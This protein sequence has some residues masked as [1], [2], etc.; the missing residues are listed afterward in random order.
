METL[1]YL[2]LPTFF[3]YCSDDERV[4]KGI[5]EDHKIRF[6]QPPALNDPLE[7]N[8]IIRFKDDADNYRSFELNGMLF[9]SE[10]LRLRAALIENKVNAFGILSLTK[11]PDS[12]DMWSRYATGH[13]GF[14]LEFKPDFNKCACM[15]STNGEEYP[16]REVTYVEEYALDIQELLDDQKWIA[17]QAVNDRMFFT[18]TSR[19]EHE[20]EYR[21]VR[22]LADYPG[23]GPL[24][25]KFHRDRDNIYL[26]EFPI[27]CIETV[28]FGACMPGG[29][30]RRIIDACK[31][32]EIHFLQAIIVRD[33][34]D[35]TGK[36]ANVLLIPIDYF[37]N[38]LEMP[39]F[40]T[41]EKYIEE[42]KRPIPLRS[43]ED[44][45][46]YAKDREWVEQY[47]RNR[48]ARQA[49]Q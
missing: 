23:W 36:P 34:K 3:K 18:K 37:P 25:D 29:K 39:D 19:W 45:P 41:E 20:R 21:M 16:V 24:P 38:F 9:P 15:R 28:T 14:L 44:L 40:F 1:D 10:E 17:Q 30:K 13:K 8:P 33:Q 31:A 48:N 43:L 5:F 32:T 12:F 46:Y 49:I 47:R 7:F 26:F 27:D 4:L 42:S 35:R 11:V 6:T 2:T 22:T